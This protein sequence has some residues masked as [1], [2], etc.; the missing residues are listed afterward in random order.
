MSPGR[1]SNHIIIGLAVVVSIVSLIWWFSG[2][3][4]PSEIEVRK[5]G[6]DN[7]PKMEPRSDTVIIGEFFSNMDP[8]NDIVPGNWPRFRR[9]YFDNINHDTILLS[10]SWDTG[11]PPV[12]WK[13]SVGEG[14]SG[15]SVHKGRVYVLDYNERIKADMLRCFSLKSGE[16]LWRRWYF[17]DIKRN[18]GYSRTVPAVTDKYMVS[19]GP[20][21][22]VMCV[23]PVTG[24]LFWTLD[25]EKEFAIPGTTKG[26][27]TPDW[28]TGQCPLIDD[29]VVVLAPGGKSL[30]IG[31]DCA[32]GKELWRT[33]NHDSLR[34][35]HGSI[36]PMTIHGRKMYVYNAI[37]GVCGVS[38]EGSDK[39]RL[40]W[41]TKEW[42]PATT[43]ASPLYL[44]NNEI[45]VF[46][47][48]GAG[49]ARLRIDYDGTS[50]S[51][52]VI[53]THKAMEGASS[54]QHTPIITG[55]L[56]WTVMPENAGE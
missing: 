56:L 25:M 5:A 9:Q 7:R 8:L 24:D 52:K 53:E 14:Y 36:M 39:G 46:G 51:A 1:I 22:H 11:G 49:G 3:H 37:G 41:L 31:V 19:I 10:D 32:T 26:K 42:N 4:F 16:E 17:V 40:L 12:A 33:P 50:F 44:E 21:S 2:D 29:G 48:Y 27:I 18:H 35:S 38:A 23:D 47:S 45:A 30:M 34:M 28:Y 15:P 54:D 55:N 20:R 13:I 6:M 43:A